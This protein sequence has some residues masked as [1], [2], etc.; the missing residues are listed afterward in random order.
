MN[1]LESDLEEIIMNTP[2]HKLQ[3]AGLDSIG[4][5]FKKS[6]VRIGGY[7]ISDII[8]YQTE[9][10]VDVLKDGSYDVHDFS[11]TITIYELKKDKVS[12]SSFAQAA[13]YMKGVQ[14][15]FK[16][17]NRDIDDYYWRIVLIGKSVD[18]NSSMLYF[19]DFFNSDLKGSVS[20]R[21]YEYSFGIDGLRFEEISDFNLKYNGFKTK[22]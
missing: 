17:T 3:N 2:N 20:V 10:D 12:L 6:Q 1:F 13:N 15:Y 19:P 22:K 21:Y 18:K 7:G 11:K 4:V 16:Y 8:T 14:Q 9:P 5:G